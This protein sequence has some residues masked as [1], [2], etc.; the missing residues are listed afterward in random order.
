MCAVLLACC[1]HSRG[2]QKEE[3]DRI[4]AVVGLGD[5]LPDQ[6]AFDGIPVPR[7]APPSASARAPSTFPSP[8]KQKPSRSIKISRSKPAKAAKPPKPRAAVR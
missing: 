6:A 5:E 7:T 1:A 8:S 4:D 3:V 2:W